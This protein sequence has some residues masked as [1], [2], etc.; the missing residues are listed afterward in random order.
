MAGIYEKY[1][2]SAQGVDLYW[3]KFVPVGSPGQKF[4]AVVGLHPGGY[5]HGPADLTAQ[6]TSLSKGGLLF[7]GTEYPLA[8]PGVEMN[9]VTHVLGFTSGNHPIPGQNDALDH[10]F[11]PE[12]TEA[13]KLA[14]RTARAH[15]LCDGRVYGIG[16]SAGASHVI[17]NLLTATGD[18]LFDLGVCCSIGVYDLYQSQIWAIPDPGNETFPAGAIVNY[19]NI[20][21]DPNGGVPPTGADLQ[22]AKN[23]SPSFYFD[24]NKLG[25][26]I[27]VMVSDHDSPGIPTST[28][29]ELDSWKKDGTAIFLMER[30]SN[31]HPVTQGFVSIAN[32]SGMTESTADVPEPGTLKY[33]KTVVVCDTAD[34]GNSR[35]AHAFNYWPYYMD[36]SASTSVQVGAAVLHWFLGGAVQQGD[37]PTIT[38]FEPTEGVAGVTSV[39]ITGTGFNGA[40]GVRF[41]KVDAL[42][43]T[44]DSDTQITAVPPIAGTSGEIVVSNPSGVAHSPDIFVFVHPTI[45][46]PLVPRQPILIYPSGGLPPVAPHVPTPPLNL[47]VTP[48][49][50]TASHKARAVWDAPTDTGGLS[51]LF[52]KASLTSAE[53]FS[54]T[55]PDI[56]GDATTADLDGLENDID[57]TFHL[58]AQN[59]I[60]FSAETAVLFHSDPGSTPTQKDEPRGVVTLL[61]QIQSAPFNGRSKYKLTEVFGY[62]GN[63]PQCRG[64]R[65]RTT[66]AQ[67]QP[68]S[69]DVY[70]WVEID[71]YLALCTTYNQ[72]AGI[73]ISAGITCPLWFQADPRVHFFPVTRPEVG[74]MVIP[75]DDVFLDYWVGSPVGLT[76][77]IDAFATRYDD[78][79]M[80]RYVSLG[81]M[82][83]I[84]ETAVAQDPTELDALT[85]LAQKRFGS[86]REGWEY[87]VQRIIGRA[88][89]VFKHTK[90]VVT[91]VLPVPNSILV[92]PGDGDLGCNDAFALG[93]T[94]APTT[95]GVM[96][97]GLNPN[98]DGT[99]PNGYPPFNIIHDNSYRMTAGFQFVH[100]ADSIDPT[101]PIG[102]FTDTVNAGIACN[103]KYIEAYLHDAIST[104]PAFQAVITAANTSMDALP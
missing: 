84:I 59:A 69:A 25:G 44:V 40:N 52:Y 76:S 92:N 33:K 78:H 5:A 7:F 21:T 87:A 97:A 4:P 81:G 43:F 100:P 45:I 17:F 46:V 9:S 75:W 26:K 1:G 39:V 38:G 42:S 98:T 37:P 77:F 12:Q 49:G 36:G 55:I 80:L 85:V 66:W 3:T 74:N 64:S 11:A 35:H 101:D 94:R 13:V 2:T 93:I 19:L 91:L 96:N 79:P 18:D 65:Y 29:I 67:I 16:G 83:Q 50:Q 102:A 61:A 22:I 48:Q 88:T 68:D 23:A 14:V 41:N 71:E 8:P 15:E 32:A 10:G 63:T 58:Q 6:G 28:G 20:L 70:N 86:I 34:N 89:T 30:A 82:G 103:G 27:W 95:F 73:S 57:Y 60:G 72:W 99:N 31:G 90:S 56:P 62:W 53:G 24:K 51:L 54:G 104:D 47:V